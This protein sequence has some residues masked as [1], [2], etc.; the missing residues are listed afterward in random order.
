[1]NSKRVNIFASLMIAF[2]LLFSV[3]AFADSSDDDSS[4]RGS[5]TDDPNKQYD[6][7]DNRPSGGDDSAVISD[8]SS[9]DAV[10]ELYDD[11]DSDKALGDSLTVRERLREKALKTVQQYKE[12]RKKYQ[13]RVEEYKEIKDRISESKDKL[14]EARQRLASAPAARKVTMR[15]Q[16]FERAK[17][18]LSNK[19][20]AL[21][22]QLERLSGQ[23]FEEEAIAEAKAFLDEK[24]TAVDSA[25]TPEELR[26]I[27]KE[28]NDKWGEYR[29][30]I[31][32]KLGLHIN[33]RVQNLLEKADTFLERMK[34][35]SMELKDKG[36]DTE[37]LDRLI[38]R[39]EERL[40]KFN[41]AYTE[42]QALYEEA[43]S[44]RDANEVIKKGNRLAVAV[45]KEI[46]KY[47]RGLKYAFNAMR[48]LNN[49]DELSQEIQDNIDSFV[50]DS[51]DQEFEDALTDIG[52]GVE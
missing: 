5:S 40:A 25:E 21:L 20:E 17:G 36:K 51:I 52:G 39:L 43:D 30:N 23:G 32:K 34:T 7:S 33:A 6:D 44:A 11:S 37:P 49:G 4:D 48:E 24:K 27:W 29:S 35:L 41:D 45:N 2:L 26:A 14:D 31:K 46:V 22:N 1:M 13:N 16:Y 42:L 15:A 18:A 50:D 10:P 38:T 8:D 12:A 19:L 3:F 9:N 28:L 47:F